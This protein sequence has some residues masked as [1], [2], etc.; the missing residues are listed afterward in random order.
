MPDATCSVEVTLLMAMVERAVAAKMAD[1][2]KLRAMAVVSGC[3]PAA[4]N[5]RNVAS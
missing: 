2:A 1:M 5:C 4:S 3:S